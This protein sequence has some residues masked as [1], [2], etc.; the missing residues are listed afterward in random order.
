MTAIAQ[1][2]DDCGTTFDERAPLQGC[3]AC[4]GLLTVMQP[5]PALTGSA[6]RAH[7]DQRRSLDPDGSGVWRFAEVVQPVVDARDIVSH[8]EGRTPLL[9]RA[10]LAAWCGID[11]IVIKHEG[12]N[13]TGSFKDRGMT[14]AVTQ[15]RRIGARAVACASTGNT[16]ASLADYAAQASLTALVFMPHGKVAPG[17][18]A[19]ASAYGARVVT[20]EGDF[21]DALRLARSASMELDVYLV[22]S[23]N[24]FRIEGQKT[25]ILDILQQL[26]WDAPDWIVFPAGNLGNASAFGKALREAHEWGLIDRIPRLAAIQASGAAPFAASYRRGFDRLIPVHAATIATAIQIGDPASYARAVRAISETHGV[27]TDVSD[28]EILE[29]KG[30]IDGAGVGCEPAS[31]AALAGVRKL[32]AE[33][34]IGRSDRVVAILTGHLLKDPAPPSAPSAPVTVV[35]DTASVA[36]VLAGN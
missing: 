12:H 6:L 28:A 8:P 14:V 34:T 15:A 17:K 21:D 2:C 29:A 13:P 31:A 32:A 23:V 18:L 19:Q 16:S 11:R 20:V 24:P 1:R 9:S 33:G 5:A 22:N 27:A 35:H 7:F 26:R 25:I 36:R 30:A 4:G 3:R 10:A